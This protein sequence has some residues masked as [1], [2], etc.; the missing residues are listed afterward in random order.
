[1]DRLRLRLSELSDALDSDALTM[2]QFVDLNTRTLR[3][4]QEIETEIVSAG[5]NGAIGDLKIGAE[6]LAEQWL[7]ADLKMK[8][9]IVSALF[10]V[11]IYPANR[12]KNV[13]IQERVTVTVKK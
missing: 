13:P 2:D 4:I 9:D 1:V 6:D 5:T 11:T 8:R 7:N 10:D 3:K 12:R